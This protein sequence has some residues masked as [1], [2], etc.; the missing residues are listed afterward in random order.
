MTSTLLAEYAYILKPGGIVYAVT[1]V[2][3][4]HEWMVKHLD[5]HPLF[6]R[7]DEAEYKSDPC[8]E[9]VMKETEEGKK[10]ERNN[11]DKYFACFRRVCNE[12]SEWV[13]FDPILQVAN[14]QDGDNNDDQSDNQ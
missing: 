6:E 2:L 3:D 9:C 5:E 7:I 4:L 8:V 13:G 14:E 11:G 12:G 10:V 1:D